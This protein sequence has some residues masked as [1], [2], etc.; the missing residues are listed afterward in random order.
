MSNL[1]KITA[2]IIISI[3]CI[4]IIFN[5]FI[6][7]RNQNFNAKL[8]FSH[9]GSVCVKQIRKTSILCTPLIIGKMITTNCMPTTY[10][11]YDK[12]DYINSIEP[13]CSDFV[14]ANNYFIEYIVTYE[15]STDKYIN[16]V[17]RDKNKAT[18]LMNRKSI[19]A[20][21]DSQGKEI[22]EIK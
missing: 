19:L 7:N 21:V 11:S 2:P 15:L 3:C 20:K 16:Y 10:Y 4:V 17:T 14:G 12:S 6:L 8:D 1:Q 9:V 5:L 22:L 18:E 13:D